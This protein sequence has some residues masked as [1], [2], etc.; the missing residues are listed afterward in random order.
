MDHFFICF[1]IT[2]EPKDFRTSTKGSL[3]FMSTQSTSQSEI[4]DIKGGMSHVTDTKCYKRS[5]QTMRSGTSSYAVI[6]TAKRPFSKKEICGIEGGMNHVTNTKW[7]K[8]SEQTIRS[9]TSGCTI[10]A[11]QNYPSASIVLGS[12]PWEVND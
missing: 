10:F 5:E 7:Y 8:R 4:C 12:G 1:R 11:R 2:K 6:C 9:E 3:V